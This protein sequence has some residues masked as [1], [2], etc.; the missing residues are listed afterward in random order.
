MRDG[1]YDAVGVRARESFQ[2]FV[3]WLIS[4]LNF[5]QPFRRITVGL[6]ASDTAIFI[7]YT[8][9]DNTPLKKGKAVPVSPRMST[10][11]ITHPQTTPCLRR[12]HCACFPK[13]MNRKMT[14]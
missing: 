8:S 4:E 1:T 2:G 6:V 14:P 5:I 7:F 13:P 12:G 9:S 11:P 3:S 10:W